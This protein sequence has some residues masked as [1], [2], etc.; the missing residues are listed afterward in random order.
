MT[1]CRDLFGLDGVLTG[2]GLIVR[3]SVICVGTGLAGRRIAVVVGHQPVGCTVGS[4][5]VE[6]VASTD[7][8]GHVA[9]A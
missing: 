4:V 9:V 3:S 2:R 7:L 1:L 5:V 6:C 8:T